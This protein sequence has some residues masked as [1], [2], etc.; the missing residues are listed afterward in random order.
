[1]ELPGYE[2]VERLGEGA[3]AVVW[4]AHQ[5]SLERMVAI[6]VLKREFAQ[7]PKEVNDFI[8]EARSAAQVKHA[9]IVQ[10]FDVAELDD[11]FYIVMEFV[12]GSPLGAT[13]SARGPI[14]PRKAIGIA[15][16]V[17]EALDKAWSSK[18][19]IHRDIKPDNI[20]VDRDG[21]VKLADLGLAMIADPAHSSAARAQELVAGTPNYM[22]PEQ[23]RG[24]A[25]IDCRADMY[26][27][28]ATLYH[29]VTGSMP[30]A[31][32]DARTIMHMQVSEQLTHP[33]NVE[34]TVPMGVAQLI[35]RLMMKRAEHRFKNW[36]EA[37]KTMKKVA[38][39]GM[40]LGRRGED[41]A[42][43]VGALKTRSE[44]A[45]AEPKQARKRGKR[46]SV[47]MLVQLPLWLL[48]GCWLVILAYYRL[49]KTAA[50]TAPEAPP[51]TVGSQ[52]PAA[53]KPAPSGTTI[54]GPARHTIHMPSHPTLR[55]QLE[56]D[57][58]AMLSMAAYEP[59]K[60]D[61]MTAEEREHYARICA[62]TARHLMAEEDDAA[63]A[64]VDSALR[65]PAAAVLAKELLR[66]KAF[67][68]ETTEA[69]ALVTR[70]LLSKVG[71][72]TVLHYEGED[73]RVLLQAMSGD[74]V[75]GMLIE[76][77][78]NGVASNALLFAASALD[79]IERSRWIGPAS[80]PERCAMKFLLYYAR[81]DY[82]T[83][84]HFAGNC[85]PFADTFT[86]AAGQQMLS[87]Q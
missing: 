73:R 8:Q 34:P 65:E 57:R 1:M 15:M 39:G 35:E 31:G 37:I 52:Q 47:P 81:G 9:N 43:T 84:L 54:V 20:L 19:I 49:T 2:I 80:S 25:E 72:E 50:P 58:A 75:R 11:V 4:K 45:A 33:R 36:R 59:P 71:Q 21:T 5:T 18:R 86:E 87:T 67:T 61:E 24:D 46:R 14:H 70:G 17:A 32:N 13:L 63:R 10:V 79:P 66:L 82:R 55:K 62:G 76:R 83:A 3:M 77:R 60:T 48:L 23:I 85:G 16:R 38:S 44:E 53:P 40:L 64:V 7:D 69:A 12:D 29:M 30:F 41:V 51:P 22:A 68:D 56:T 6:K 26:S 28:G 78:P 27:L 42:S 74:K